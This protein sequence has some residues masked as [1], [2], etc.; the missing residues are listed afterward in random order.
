VGR[1]C[2]QRLEELRAAD[3]LLQM[4]TIPDARLHMRV[5]GPMHGVFSVDVSFRERLT[6][7]PAAAP[8]PTLPDGGVDLRAVTAII[9]L[10]VDNPHE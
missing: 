1:K 4:K 3:C 10:G 7:V 8:V 2:L 6:F 9:I 5:G